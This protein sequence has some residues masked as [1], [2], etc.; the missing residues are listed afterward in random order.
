[1]IADVELEKA[2]M[3]IINRIND[4]SDPEVRKQ[5]RNG[6]I[7]EIEWAQEMIREGIKKNLNRAQLE[8]YILAEMRSHRIY[9]KSMAN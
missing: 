1:M 5:Y 2:I 3:E 8:K 6:V 9:L 4:I 7:D